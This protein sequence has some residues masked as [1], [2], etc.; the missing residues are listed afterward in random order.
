VLLG[1]LE[2]FGNGLFGVAYVHDP[3]TYSKMTMHK[4]VPWA[5]ER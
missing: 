5:P 2:G 1:A 3:C 4:F